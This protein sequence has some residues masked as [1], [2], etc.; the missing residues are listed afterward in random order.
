MKIKIILLILFTY[1]S[2]VYSQ[3]QGVSFITEVSKKKLGVNVKWNGII[4]HA[5]AI[6][7]H[8][9]PN[10]TLHLLG[11][12]LKTN[13]KH[14]H[15]YDSITGFDQGFYNKF[16]HSQNFNYKSRLDMMYANFKLLQK[17]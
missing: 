10:A 5:I 16:C 1:Y 8:I 7:K 11:I 12:D 4:F 15:F 6:A 17:N 14:H 13:N 2:S 3:D 9:A